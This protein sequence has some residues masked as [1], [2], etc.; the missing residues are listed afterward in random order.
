MNSSDTKLDSVPIVR[1]T[2]D[3]LASQPTFDEVAMQLVVTL[4]STHHPRAALISVFEQD[5]SLHAAGSFGL[6]DAAILSS[7]KI[8]LWDES[9]ISEAVRSGKPFTMCDTQA[10]GVKYPMLTKQGELL[11][12]TVAWPLAVRERQIGAIEVLFSEE[13]D[14]DALERDFA[15]MM[16]IMSLYLAMTRGGNVAVGPDFKSPLGIQHVGATPA[17]TKTHLTKRQLVIL[18]LMARHMTNAQIANRIGYSESTIRQETIA[19]YRFLGA[20]GRHQAVELARL[21]GLL[22]E[23]EVPIAEETKTA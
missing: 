23:E 21:R 13:P 5:G 12:P 16:P 4:L 19:I 2:V 22:V 11:L 17:P 18:D 6:T 9:P 1:A 8:S 10:L 20:D 3:F 7:K 14:V 15:V